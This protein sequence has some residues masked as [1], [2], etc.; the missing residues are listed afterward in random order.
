MLGTQISMARYIRDYMT[1]GKNR[2]QLIPANSG[3]E[4][5][6]IEAQ[7]SEYNALQLRRNNLVANSSEQNPLIVDLDHSL[8]AMRE[9]IVTSIDNLVISSTPE[10]TN[11]NAANSARRHVSPPIPIRQSICKRSV[12]SRRSRRRFTSS[13]CKNARKTSCRKR[14]QPIISVC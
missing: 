12:A 2:N 14:L 5:T 10:R 6:G 1:G 8:A 13:C 7:I 9:A 11:S 3:L 4:S